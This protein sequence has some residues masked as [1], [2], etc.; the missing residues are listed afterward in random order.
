M[1][2]KDIH[3]KN[4]KKK[5]IISIIFVLIVL[6][7]ILL[8]WKLMQLNKTTLVNTNENSNTNEIVNNINENTMENNINITNTNNNINLSTEETT[9]STSS[10]ERSIE[11]IQK[12]EDKK[13]KAITIAKNNWGEDNTVYFTF[14]SIDEDGNYLIYIRDKATTHEVAHYIV[15]IKTGTCTLQ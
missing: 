11:D 6:L 15:D 8:T 9:N 1:S 7:T 3:M 10:E 2:R 4:E 5:I 14:D 12:D 13:E